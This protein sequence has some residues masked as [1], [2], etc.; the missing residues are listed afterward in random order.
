MKLLYTNENV[1]LVNN[2]RNIIENLGIEIVLKNEF[3]AGAVGEVSPFD[4][5]LELW[6]EESD[7]EKATQALVNIDKGDKTTEWVCGQCHELN[8]P[9]FEICWQCQ[10][11]AKNIR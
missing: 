3:A 9:A 7:Y 2:V 1:F 6:V 4:T 10:S 5:W 11:E 8:D